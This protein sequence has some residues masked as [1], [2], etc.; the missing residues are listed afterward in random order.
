MKK[1]TDLN[2]AVKALYDEYLD[3]N[4]SIEHEAITEVRNEMKKEIETV[5]MFFIKGLKAFNIKKEDL[6]KLEDD[7]AYVLFNS[8]KLWFPTTECEYFEM[9]CWKV[10]APQTYEQPEE[11]DW[12]DASQEVF[13]T[14]EGALRAIFEHIFNDRLSDMFEY[15]NQLEIEAMERE[16]EE[17]ETMDDMISDEDVEYL[18]QQDAR[19]Q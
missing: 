10:F 11:A 15:L 13:E 7:N 14:F 9:W 3:N 16:M 17:T 12:D 6:V 2:S 19:R 1:I 4:T 18:I 8:F 5:L